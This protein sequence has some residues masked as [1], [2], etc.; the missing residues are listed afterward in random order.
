M[1][2]TILTGAAGGVLLALG[3][4]LVGVRMGALAR[5]RLR[6]VIR[7]RE[8]ELRRSRLE[9]SGVLKAEKSGLVQS[10]NLPV[11]PPAEDA[12]QE[13]LQEI[14]RRDAERTE[15][16][17]NQLQSLQGS[18]RGG[19]GR[20]DVLAAQVRDVV[21]PLADRARMQAA[22]TDLP[23]DYRH[24]GHLSALLATVA[25]RAALSSVIL[26]D[27]A[28]L[29]LAEASADA[30]EALAAA[31][32]LLL[33]LTDRLDSSGQPAAVGAVVRDT[34]GRLVLH[35]IFLAGR[36]RYVLTG[37]SKGTS[38]SP[39]ALDPV[40]PQIRQLLVQPGP[41]VDAVA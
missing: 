33:T 37:V 5:E 18:L 13:R 11:I 22:L 14:E 32:S 7:N 41:I 1:L 6:Q 15:A 10:S 39:E 23:D 31:A 12:L 38:L 8:E 30:S 26:S 24:R 34:E 21:G 40:L 16:L 2:E 27:E 9:L 20:Q 19:E 3:G 4:Y 35:R 28:G 17:M 36:E 25:D 29:P